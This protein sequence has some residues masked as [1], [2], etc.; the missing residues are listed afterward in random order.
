MWRRASNLLYWPTEVSCCVYTLQYPYTKPI[1][2]PL[3]KHPHCANINEWT[4]DLVAD[5]GT[6]KW[7]TKTRYRASTLSVWRC[8]PRRKYFVWKMC[9]TT[10]FHNLLMMVS[11]WS[12]SFMTIREGHIKH[13]HMHTVKVDIYDNN[14][15]CWLVCFADVSLASA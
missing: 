11:Q 15:T 12:S 10:T 7:R 1:S 5:V 2:N 9:D 6:L 8:Q 14:S 4:G 13:V 3:S